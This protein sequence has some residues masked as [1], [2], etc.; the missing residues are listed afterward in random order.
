M[1]CNSSRTKPNCLVVI[2]IVVIL[3]IFVFLIVVIVIIIVVVIHWLGLLAG[4]PARTTLLTSVALS[5]TTLGSV[6]SDI[7]K[8]KQDV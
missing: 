7:L 5:G 1:Q 6:G 2:L 8:Q 4:G 3:I